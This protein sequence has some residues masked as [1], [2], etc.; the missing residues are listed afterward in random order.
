MLKQAALY[1]DEDK[2]LQSARS[3]ELG[4]LH[5]LRSNL[6]YYYKSNKST[7][8]KDSIDRFSEF[9]TKMNEAK[10]IQELMTIEA[11]ARQLYFQ[12]F[13]E[14]IHEERFRFI[15]RTKMPPRDPLN[16]LISFGNTYIYNRVATEISKTSLDLRIGFLH[17]LTNR[18]QSLN[19]DIAEI[20]KQLIV[21]RTIFTIINKR[22]INTNDHFEKTEDNGI[23]LNRAGKRLYIKEL[24]SKI[25]SKRVEGNQA[26][27]YDSLIRDEIMKIYRLV[28]ADEK[29]KPYKYK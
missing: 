18:N 5:N 21:D 19:L 20:F 3:L 24:D 17:S 28:W 16:A 22:M 15:Q 1:L 12:M 4:A 10:T 6:R 14:I 7:C 2:R 8:L 25:Y 11:R 26:A 9:M 13:N 27:N 23:Y 29:S